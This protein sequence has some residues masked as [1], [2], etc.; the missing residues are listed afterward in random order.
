MLTLTYGYK[1]PQ[2]DDTGDVFFPAM[3]ANIQQLNDH[4]HDGATSA[5]IP[6]ASAVVAHAGWVAAG[7]TT[8]GLYTQVI[9]LPT[10]RAYDTTQFTVRDSAGNVTNNQITKASASTYNIFT[11]DNTQ[12]LLVQYGV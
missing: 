5:I 12:D 4:T 1:K 8:P 7:L 10:G 3:E 11:N 9:T 2:L 6:T